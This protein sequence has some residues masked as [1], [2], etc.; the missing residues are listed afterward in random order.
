MNTTVAKTGAS[1]NRIKKALQNVDLLVFCLPGIIATFIY[2]YIPLYGVQLAFRKDSRRSIFGGEW[3]GLA[4]FQRFFSSAD[5]GQIIWNTFI[6][7]LYCLVISMPIAMLLALMLNSFRHK[8]YRK[9]IQSVTY[10]P[11]FISTVVMAGMIILFLH[12]RIGIV[13]TLIVSMGGQRVN[14]MGKAQYWRHIYVWTDV[15]QKMGWNSIIYFATL[16]SVSPDFHEAAVVDGATKFQR[17]IHIDFPFLLPTATI[18]LILNFGS[19]FDIAFDKV[20]ALQ[21]DLNKSVSQ[22]ISTYVY[23]VGLNSARPS[24]SFSAAVGLFQSLI[25]TALLVCVNWIAGR[26]SDNS[27]F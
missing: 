10:A 16:S 1:G 18:L 20:Y 4:N 13:N 27:L 7:S 15:W 2:H 8:R 22:I 6:L 25:N 11:Y 3:I 9:V 17:L 21:N 24:P 12:P 5:A 23:E 19:F 14:F 26:A